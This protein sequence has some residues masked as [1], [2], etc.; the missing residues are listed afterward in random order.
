MKILFGF[1]LLVGCAIDKPD[2]PGETTD[3]ARAVE[4]V[5]AAASYVSFD[6]TANGCH[7]R[8]I[9]LAAALASAGIPSNTQFIVANGDLLLRP[10]PYPDLE[11]S[12]HVA[13]LIYL[14]GSEPPR[15][16]D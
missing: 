6:Y 5:R 11:W 1:V 7:D 16:R 14:P 2:E 3:L 13:P 8:S 9:L 15:D 4:A 10:K 12:Y